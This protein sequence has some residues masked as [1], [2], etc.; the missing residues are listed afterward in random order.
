M[1]ES[2][3][4]FGVISFAVQSAGGKQE[5]SE[6]AVKLTIG[7]EEYHIVSE[8]VGPVNALDR[9]LRK[10]LVPHYPG[11]EKFFISDYKVKVVDSADGTEAEVG[12]TVIISDAERIHKAVGF[13]Q[14]II[15]ASLVAL[16]RVYS[17]AASLPAE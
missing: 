4:F 6:A 15:F 13:S 1:I 17:G 10:A 16:C 9:A 3:A 8:G 12:V 7:G 14:D 11:L 5:G 2:N